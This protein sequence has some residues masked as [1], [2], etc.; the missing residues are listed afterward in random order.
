MQRLRMPTRRGPAEYPMLGA[1]LY[2]RMVDVEP[3]LETKLGKLCNA[4]CLDVMPMLGK[5]NIDLIFANP[6]F[7]LGKDYGNGVSD[8]LKDHEYLDGASAG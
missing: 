8:S 2:A 5:G 4:D 6:P 3:T 1:H 7:N